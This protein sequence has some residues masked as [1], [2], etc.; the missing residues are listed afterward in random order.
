[1]KNSSIL[2]PIDFSDNSLAAI[3]Y[4]VEIAI[5]LDSKI[6]LLHCFQH[7]T[8]LYNHDTQN[9]VRTLNKSLI[10]EHTE[11]LEQ[12]ISKYILQEKQP[13]FEIV[14]KEGS[15]N[16][17]IKDNVEALSPDFI[18]M[19]TKGITNKN[20]GGMGSNTKAVI[21]LGLAPVIVIP[22]NSEFKGLKKAI[23]ATDFNYSD[24][25]GIKFLVNLAK[26]VNGELILVHLI[27]AD[28]RDVA[29]IEANK[30]SRMLN[31][32]VKYEHI[33]LQL[34]DRKDII[35]TL[36]LLAKTHQANLISMTTRKRKGF[37]DKVFEKSL[38]QD[39]AMFTSVPLLAF[40]KEIPGAD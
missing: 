2:V 12:L 1:M 34:I 37:F 15:L 14:V 10:L 11:K 19:G 6:T 29:Q 32:H 24:L 27:K 36:G 26:P 8:P 22:E 9:F 4:A 39:M 31:E 40:V 30:F 21:D 23:Y 3:D 18:V 13:E 5:I 20:F 33:S 17:I 35:D 28:E 7:E 25:A 16:S 38:T